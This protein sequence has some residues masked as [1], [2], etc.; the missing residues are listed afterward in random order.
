M[1]NLLSIF[2]KV[3]PFIV[4]LILEVFSFYI[5]YKNDD[6]YNSNIVNKSNA[7][8]GDYYSNID[9]VNS[10]FELKNVN[11]NLAKTNSNLMEQLY[12]KQLLLNKYDEA[13]KYRGDSSI[14]YKLG[15]NY[16]IINA[17]VI[18][19]SVSKTRNYI[20][21]N[22]GINQGVQKDMGVLGE[23]GP[24]GVVIET[25]A[26]YSCVMSLLNKD[27]NFSCRVKSTQQVGQLKWQGSDIRLAKLED[28]PKHIKLKKGEIIETSGFSTFFP[29][30]IRIGR[31]LK[32]KDNK[33]SNF[34]DITVLLD[35]DFLKLKH[36]YIV[37]VNKQEEVKSLLNKYNNID[38]SASVK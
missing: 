1:G 16:N 24:I 33:E 25:S 8:V 15:S 4:F 5:I 18:N 34:A 22:K 38:N 14:N 21:I 12:E 30:N 9:N 27:A 11:D 29:E 26:N 2:I 31:V 7:I 17:K 20:I 19:N 6:Y 13:F 37:Q 10:Y 23:K 3:F 32:Q 36:V 35:N 28:I